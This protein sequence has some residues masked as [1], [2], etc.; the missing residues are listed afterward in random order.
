[1]RS[2]SNSI[3]GHGHVHVECRRDGFADSV[4]GLILHCKVPVFCAFLSRDT[5]ARVPACVFQTIPRAHYAA[6]RQATRRARRSGRAA[7]AKRPGGLGGG[8]NGSGNVCKIEQAVGQA[9][10]QASPVFSSTVSCSFVPFR[11]HS[12]AATGFDHSL[13]SRA[14]R[15][16]IST[17]VYC[18]ISTVL[19][20][21]PASKSPT[22]VF[23]CTVSPC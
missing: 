20:H 15:P 18:E 14:C 12:S 21:C 1:M 11:F 4:F 5:D 6:P 8:V 13:P 3:H 10:S 2:L 19:K 9:S 17:G 16:L 23:C 7:P 22:D